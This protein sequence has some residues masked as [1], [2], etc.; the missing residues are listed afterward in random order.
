MLVS[1]RRPTQCG[2]TLRLC[3]AAAFVAVL[4]GG[5]VQVLP[6]GLSAEAKQSESQSADNPSDQPDSYLEDETVSFSVDALPPRETYVAMQRIRY[7]PGAHLAEQPS[8]GP[9]LLNVLSG[10]LTF[11]TP[12]SGVTLARPS[13]V[14]TW[15]SSVEPGVDQFVSQ[16]MTVM[17]PAGIPAHLSN[18]SDMPVEW[19]QFEVETPAALCACGE[20]RSAAD[21][22][23]LSS[24]TLTGPILSPAVVSLTQQRL[25]PGSDI[26]IPPPGSIQ[27]IGT[28]S[29][30]ARLLRRDDGSARNDGSVAIT[31]FVAT[32]AT[33]NTPDPD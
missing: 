5:I 33:V 6:W 23:V 29:D 12:V 27:I 26:A 24:K 21:M 22:E 32:I 19:I 16:G 31:V 4:S 2:R 10:L 8:D 17:I 15:S 14:G 30:G 13:I 28:V 7:L 9:K 3:V 25:D 20:D 1:Q 11:R 18:S